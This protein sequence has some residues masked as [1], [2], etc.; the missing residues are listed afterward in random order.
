MLGNAETRVQTRK[1]KYRANVLVAQMVKNLPAVQETWVCSLGLEDPLEEDM[2]TSSSFPAGKIPWA[3]EPG[4]L[5]SI[6]LKRVPT[7]LSD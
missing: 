4:K 7:R 1:S 5:Q 6:G 2:A 3:K